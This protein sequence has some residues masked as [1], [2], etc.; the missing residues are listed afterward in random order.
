M[1]FFSRYGGIDEAV[2]TLVFRLGWPVTQI[3]GMTLPEL[4]YWLKRGGDYFERNR[5]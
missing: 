5:S 3:Q 2:D 4:A 1:R